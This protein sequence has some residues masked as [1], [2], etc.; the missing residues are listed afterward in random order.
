MIKKKSVKNKILQWSPVKS[1]AKA[2]KSVRYG[3]QIAHSDTADYLNLY[4]N[5]SG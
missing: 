1:F 2:V 3:L 5:I 4:D